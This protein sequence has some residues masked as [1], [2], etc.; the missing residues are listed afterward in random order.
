MRNSS[1]ASRQCIKA[2]NI[3]KEGNL[4]ELTSL[5]RNWPPKIDHKS[6]FLNICMA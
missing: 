3:T 4:P 1:G 6:I 5:D 2:D